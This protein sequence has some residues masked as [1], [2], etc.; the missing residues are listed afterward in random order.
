[1]LQAG[2][3]ASRRPQ[4]S[5]WFALKLHDN[6]GGHCGGA[7]FLSLDW[8]ETQTEGQWQLWG[9]ERRMRKS[10]TLRLPSSFW[11]SFGPQINSVPPVCK[12]CTLRQVGLPARHFA[13]EPLSLVDLWT[14]SLL[15]SLP[16]FL[17]FLYT[18]VVTLYWLKPSYF[19]I[20]G[21]RVR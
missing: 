12:A 8:W 3:R 13:Q 7:G 9:V 10:C 19:L 14:Q 1:M 20:G 18:F 15:F 21:T 2:S 5:T 17:F 6:M 4:K 11:S 16:P